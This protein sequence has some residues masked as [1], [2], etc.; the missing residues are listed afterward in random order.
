MTD[1]KRNAP[2]HGKP[3]ALLVYRKGRYPAWAMPGFLLAVAAFAVWWIWPP[4]VEAWSRWLW[5]DI[6][7]LDSS[8]PWLIAGIAGLLLMLLALVGPRSATVQAR[9]EALRI[10]TLLGHIDIPYRHINVVRSVSFGYVYP[11][12]QVAKV[13]RGWIKKFANETAVGVDMLSLPRGSLR[14]IGAL[15]GPY[16][17]SRKDKLFV[18][19]VNDYMTLSR[20]IDRYR[21]QDMEEQKRNPPKQDATDQL[22]GRLATRR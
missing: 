7:G 2:K 13:D 15:L 9:Q 20:E 21:M 10:G 14:K 12:D 5:W 3:Y 6:L 1:D 17:F 11:P 8:M 19:L 22:L 16:V 18:F 4:E